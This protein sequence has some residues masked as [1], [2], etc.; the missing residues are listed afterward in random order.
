MAPWFD[1]DSVPSLDHVR[2]K[3]DLHT[4]LPSGS[5]RI[6]HVIT[7][8]FPYR[9]RTMNELLDNL[10]QPKR[11]RNPSMGMTAADEAAAISRVATNH[12]RAAS[13]T[14]TD[15]TLVASP[16]PPPPT[17]QATTELGKPLIVTGPPTREH[18]L[19]DKEA[20]YC[21]WCGIK[22]TMFHRKHHCRRC[23]A[24]GCS[25]CCS[26]YCRLDQ[27]ASFHPAGLQSRVCQNC[28][29]DFTSRVVPVKPLVIESES[30]SDT[31]TQ[32]RNAPGADSAQAVPILVQDDQANNNPPPQATVPS[33]WTWSTF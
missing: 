2:D 14:A 30:T 4:H 20:Q 8:L 33:D 27:T 15:T 13:N 29:S 22:F 28:Y 26:Q 5:A 6:S 11:P 7:R 3:N 21:R 24:V 19:P 12:N 9:H 10:H 25:A 16:P 1:A 31:T 17:S 32:V 18:W 23:G